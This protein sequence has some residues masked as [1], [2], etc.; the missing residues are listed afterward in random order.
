MRKRWQCNI[1]GE[2]GELHYTIDGDAE[3]VEDAL[4]AGGRGESGYENHHLIGVE[5]MEQPND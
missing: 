5:I 3:A 4:K 1:S 2:L